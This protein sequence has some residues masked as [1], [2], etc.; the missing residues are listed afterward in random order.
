MYNFSETKYMYNFVFLK[1]TFNLDLSWK[2]LRMLFIATTHPIFAS[3]MN[4]VSFANRENPTSMSFCPTLIP[5]VLDLV[6]DLLVKLLSWA[7]IN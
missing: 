2:H 7:T 3:Q 6:L 5:L 1:F 4:N